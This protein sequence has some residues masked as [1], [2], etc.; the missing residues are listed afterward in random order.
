MVAQ[1]EHT[2]E[3]R[4]GKLLIVAGAAVIIVAAF[5][6]YLDREQARELEFRRIEGQ[7]NVWEE[8]GPPPPQPS[9]PPARRGKVL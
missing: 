7:M 9:T 6:W 4:Y 5:L 1:K 3:N 2:S 8:W